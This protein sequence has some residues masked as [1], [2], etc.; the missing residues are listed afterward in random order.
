MDD[1]VTWLTAQVDE[2]AALAQLV[3]DVYVITNRDHPKFGESFWPTPRARKV[4]EDY[5]KPGVRAGLD[6]IE[7]FGP[8]RVLAEC[9][10]KRRLLQR[11][12]TLREA[13]KVASVSLLEIGLILEYRNVI[14]PRLAEEFADRP[15]YRVEWKA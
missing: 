2:D 7:A 14:L 6:L 11:Y 1:F 12:K 9:E 8:D 5:A 10:T 3:K 15:G 4:F 13:G